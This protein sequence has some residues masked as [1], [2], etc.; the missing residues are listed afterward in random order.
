M[1]LSL[2]VDYF[3]QFQTNKNMN[4]IKLI[5]LALAAF[6][7][8]ACSSEDTEN[9]GGNNNVDVS[10]L[11]V[12]I[13]NVGEAM[14]RAEYDDQKGGTYEDGTEAES[15]ISNVRF[16]FF[17]AD[18]SPYLL[19]NTENKTINWLTPKDEKNNDIDIN[20][21]D[22]DH[23]HTV[24]QIAKTVLVI[25]GKT[26]TAPHS[27]VAVIN[28]SSLGTTLG[29]GALSLEELRKKQDKQF[30]TTATAT[31]SAKN[32]V[33]ANSIYMKD[34][35]EE[36][37]VPVSGHVATD[38]DAA[39]NN[40]IDIYVERVAAKVNTTCDTSKG[41]SVGTETWNDGKWTYQLP[42]KLNDKYE[43]YVVVDGWSVADANGRATVEKVI[44]TSWD[45]TSWDKNTLGITPWTTGDYHRCF[46][47]TSVPFEGENKV[48]NKS[49]DKI[50][51]TIANG[52]VY[53]LP[54]TP[55]KIDDFKD[56]M[57]N[58]LTKV[59]VAAHLYYKDETGVAHKAEICKYKGI[60][61]LSKEDVLTV[62]ANE[63]KS[64]YFKKTGQDEN[65]NDV[66]TSIS[67]DDL[68]F[69]TSAPAGAAAILKDYEVIPQ[70]KADAE[71]YDKDHNTV[72]VAEANKDLAIDAN[73][74]Q[75]RREGRVYYY[76]PIRHLAATDTKLGYYG[77]VRNHSY[78]INI[79]DVS[80]FG[81]PVYDPEKVIDPTL[82]EEKDIYLAARINVLSWRVVKSDVNLD[83]NK[84]K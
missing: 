48:L 5:P 23:N 82:P 44:N 8:S 77:V 76:T 18:G 41:W 56:K 39:K 14:S 15:K 35:K 68:T 3:L 28:N 55:A 50:K 80:G 81:T 29:E 46:W 24:E 30:Y 43:V 26:K 79:Q 38:A 71:I 74:A 61:Y 47:G 51:S 40:P 25:N 32:F 70:I 58:S 67:K 22:K 59:I 54:N 37:A 27:I 1:P 2:H 16:Y 17:N 9:G 64:K 57:E 45:N 6:M 84:K 20:G 66:Y 33:M 49:F 52:V 83:S 60:Q 73:K 78:K 12:N 65:G 10:Y 4:K 63:N 36:Y 31:E 72:D 34:G 53:T 21:T 69:A 42:Q 7:F 62:V 11:S 75:V 13:Q 19:N